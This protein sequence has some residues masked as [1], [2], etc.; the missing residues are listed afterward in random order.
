MVFDKGFPGRKKPLMS[1]IYFQEELAT[2]RARVQTGTR[3]VTGL[4]GAKRTGL[5]VLVEHWIYQHLILFLIL[6]IK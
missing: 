6:E 3:S 5:R 1:D 2:G 4:F